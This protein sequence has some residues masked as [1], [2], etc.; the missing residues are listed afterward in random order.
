MAATPS[1]PSAGAARRPPRT[2]TTRSA[3]LRTR[4]MRC[5]L[6][7]TAT[8][9]SSA[10]RRRVVAREAAA[11]SSSW[12]VGSSSSRS[13]GREASTPA[14][15]TRWRSPLES[16]AIRRR[17]RCR[18][19]AAL[20]ASRT[21]PGISSA[22]RPAF[23]GPKATSRSTVVRTAWASGSWKS[24]PARRATT[25]GGV[26]RVSRPSTTTRPSKRPP[27]KWGTRPASA[28]RRVDLPPPEGP[29]ISSTSPAATSSD[30]PS[31]AAGPVSP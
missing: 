21:R 5:S 29:S 7:T 1:T 31:S 30:T 11:A 22:A 23:W 14:R 18:A 13:A 8:P 16:S 10:S 12:E 17:R 27:W 15:A 25:A 19:P 3:T 9:R 6:R 28:R 26:R 2:A 20:R 24:S 4:S